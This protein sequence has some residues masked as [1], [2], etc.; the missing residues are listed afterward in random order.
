MKY[1][2][3]ESISNKGNSMFQAQ[4]L[5]KY[6]IGSDWRPLTK[7]YDIYFWVSTKGLAQTQINIHK[8]SKSQGVII[9]EI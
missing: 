5:H 2:I 4:Y 9:H 8:K 3:I 6:W 7:D 1:R